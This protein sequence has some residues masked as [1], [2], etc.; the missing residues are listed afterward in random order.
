MASAHTLKGVKRELGSKGYLNQLRRTQMIPGVV[1]GKGEPALTIAVEG[2]T[3]NRIFSHS[4]YGGLFNLEIEGE[5]QPVMTLVREVQRHPVNKDVIHVDF[6][7]VSMTEEITSLVPI[8]IVGEEE[9]VKRG[10]ILQLGDKEVEVSCLPADLPESIRCDV[11]HLRVGDKITIADLE[12]PPTVQ[13]LSDP[14]AVVA[15]VLGSHRA[16]ADETAEVSEES[17]GEAETG[18]KDAE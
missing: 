18:A 4:G 12:V 16:S 1:Y 13:K 10:G 17:Q 5:P 8:L 11:S 7:A 2:K 3:V 14:E 15:L 6:L 9:V